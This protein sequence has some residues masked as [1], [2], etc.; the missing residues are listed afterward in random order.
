MTTIYR[1]C[2]AMTVFYLVMAVLCM[3][4]NQFFGF[5]NRSCW[6]LKIIFLAC[7][8]IITFFI[9]SAFFD[10]FRDFSRYI[11]IVFLVLQVVILIDFSC[12]WSDKWIQSYEKSN[13][14][15]HRHCLLFIASGLLWVVGLVTTVM[16]YYW[17]SK[18][19]G[20]SLQVFLITFTLLLGISFTLLSLTNFV[21][22]GCNPLYSSFNKFSSQCVLCISMLEWYDK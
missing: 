12:S 21:E 4:K 17:F 2:F 8:L 20:C 22:N 9:P 1:E 7:L 3:R 14:T 11:S 15:N 18:D 19:Q 16:N 13:F 6:V 10:G 5:I